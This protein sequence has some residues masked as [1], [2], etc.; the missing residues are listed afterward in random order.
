MCRDWYRRF[1]EHDFDVV[2]G[3]YEE[4]PKIFEDAELEASLVEDPWQTQE[5]LASALGVTRQ[6]ISKRLHALGINKNPST[7]VP[8]DL[9]PRDVERRFFTCEQL[10]QRQ[11]G[12]VSFIA[13]WW[14]MKNEFIT[15]TQRE[16]SSGDCPGMLLRRRLGKIF[17]LRWLCCVFGGTRSVILIMSYWIRTRP[18]LRNGVERN[19]CVWAEHCVK[20][21]H[22]TSRG[23]K[24]WF[25][26]MTTLG[27]TLPNPLKPTWKR[28]NGKSY[29]T[30]R[31][32][33]ILRRPII[34]CSGRCHMV[35][36]I[37][38]S[39]HMK[40]SKNSLIRGKPQ[41]M[42]TFTVTAFELYQKDGKKL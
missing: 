36:L 6:A 42:N 2:D 5:E 25:H 12:R 37:S 15:A 40:T 16:E 23:T 26:S 17:T 33:Q 27:L 22:N 9:K 24:K 7:W 32:P 30:C 10:L 29:P 18:S 38:S 8:Y 13:S 39:A 1:K 19:W 11:K 35:W 20:N 21:N 14:V 3:P 4:R 34:T 28:S 31:I 41:K